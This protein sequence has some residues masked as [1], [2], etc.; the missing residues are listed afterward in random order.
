MRDENSVV[1]P[2]EEFVRLEVDLAKWSTAL[3]ELDVT[4]IAEADFCV[5]PTRERVLPNSV[6]TRD[7]PV[8]HTPGVV[9][10]GS[11]MGVVDSDDARALETS[12][13]SLVGGR[14]EL[15]A[16][17]TQDPAQEEPAAL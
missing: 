2:P 15:G 12:G 4:E 14:D 6:P 17:P 9:Q 10:F 1:V 3:E 5:T 7:P 11:N 13:G 16:E 8:E